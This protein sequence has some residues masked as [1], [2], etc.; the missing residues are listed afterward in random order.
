M[1]DLCA[2]LRRCYA[3]V[4]REDPSKLRP[5]DRER[6]RSLGYIK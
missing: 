2:D 4:E 5:E 1:R 6:L 3:P